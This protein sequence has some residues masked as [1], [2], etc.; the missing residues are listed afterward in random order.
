DGQVITVDLVDENHVGTANSFIQIRTDNA[1][2]P[3]GVVVSAIRIESLGG[4]PNP[5]SSSSSSS[6]SSSSSSSSSVSSSSSS[7]SSVPVVVDTRTWGFDSAVYADAGTALFSAA[8]DA[9]GTNNIRQ[10]ASPAMFDGLYFFN[11]STSAVMRYREAG[12]SSNNRSEERRV[13]K[14]GRCRSGQNN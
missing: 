7:S 5:G 1:T 12:N 3:E 10:L 4:T 9:A 14:E 8:Y 11:S 6:V 13:G 2:G